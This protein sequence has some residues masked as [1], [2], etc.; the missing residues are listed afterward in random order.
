MTRR[1]AVPRNEM[2]LLFTTYCLLT[3]RVHLTLGDIFVTMME[4]LL[5]YFSLNLVCFYFIFYYILN[6]DGLVQPLRKTE[7]LVFEI[8]L[9]TN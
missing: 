5:M 8:G 1:S 6:F 4:C 3:G 7:L 2:Q 9:V